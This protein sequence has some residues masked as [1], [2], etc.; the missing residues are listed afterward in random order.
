MSYTTGTFTSKIKRTVNPVINEI[1]DNINLLSKQ[2]VKLSDITRIEH[3]SD[4]DNNQQFL[5]QLFVHAVDT[6]ATSKLIVNYYLNNAGSININSIKLERDTYDKYSNNKL[7]GF[8]LLPP[9]TE[10]LNYKNGGACR[11][12]GPS[13]MF[14]MYSFYF[15]YN[16]ILILSEHNII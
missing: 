10:Y 1:L 4:K 14:Y 12:L 5:I 13:P 2:R 9:D 15:R 6:H 8:E 11:P 3:L 16:Y 7:Q